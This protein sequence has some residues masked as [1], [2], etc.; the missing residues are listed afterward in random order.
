MKLLFTMF[1]VKNFFYDF[2]C[3][4]RKIKIRFI[5]QVLDDFFEQI[6]QIGQID[7]IYVICLTG[8]LLLSD[9]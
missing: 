6:D 9:N 4:Q 2:K 1:S 5:K 7:N 8:R 3:Q